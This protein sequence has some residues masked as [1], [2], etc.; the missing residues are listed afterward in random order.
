VH[1]LAHPGIRAS[2][3]LIASC[4]LWPGLAKDVA[5]W[6]RDCTACQ[7]ATVTKQPAA[8]AE[9]ISTPTQRFSHV[10]VDLVGPLPTTPDGYSYLLTAADRST[11]WFEAF[12]LRS[13]SAA[14]CAE[15]SSAGGWHVLG[16]QRC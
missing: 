12:P 1:S 11:R 8:T 14:V 10:H 4:Y 7:A 3:Q 5:A 13:T 16:C 9:Q 6:C 15:S 2:R